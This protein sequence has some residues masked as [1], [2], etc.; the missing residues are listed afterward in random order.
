[1]K[2]I[3]LT[4]IMLAGILITG[5]EPKTTNVDVINDQGGAVMQLDYRDFEQNA[6]DMIQSMLKTGALNKPGGGRY[7][8]SVGRITDDTMQGGDLTTKIMS[9]IETDMLNS[10]KAVITA[11]VGS[12]K[13]EMLQEVREL[14]NSDE[15]N[16][17]TTV[18]K[19]TL[20]APEL[21]ITGKIIQSDITVNRSTQRAEYL[22]TLK[23]SDVKT[24]LTLWQ[25]TK[26]IVKQG[27]SKSVPW[28]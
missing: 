21:T 22:F 25:D 3:I 7:V 23:L 17:D 2:T 10:G 24:G 20:V 18:E 14:R 11:A 16:Q 6:S 12:G 15:F 5:C 27:S 1:M 28:N 9:R 4:T 13:D 19:H 26:Q 8:V